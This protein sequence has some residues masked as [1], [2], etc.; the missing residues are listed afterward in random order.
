MLFNQ[1]LIR[2]KW[3]TLEMTVKIYKAKR[4]CL[5]KEVVTLMKQKNKDVD[6]TCLNACSYDLVVCICWNHCHPIYNPDVLDTSQKATDMIQ[7]QINS[8]EI[9]SSRTAFANTFYLSFNLHNV[10][11]YLLVHLNHWFKLYF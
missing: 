9:R 2:F 7:N 11:F 3:R 10:L 4:Q 1:F 8:K 5:K 6:Y